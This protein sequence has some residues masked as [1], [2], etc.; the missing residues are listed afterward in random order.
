MK[1]FSRILLVAAIAVGCA[2]AANAQKADLRIGYGGYTQMDGGNYAE[3]KTKTAWGALTA[4]V[5]FKVA[6]KF[7][8]GPSYTFSSAGYKHFDGTA[9]YHVILLNTR[10]EY[11]RNNIVKLSGHLGLGVIITHNSSGDY[12]ETEG[13]FGFHVSPLSAEFALTRGLDFFTEI[14]YGAMGVIQAGVRIS[15]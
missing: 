13:H 6:P 5:D 14:G 1:T 10:Y 8:L 7:R 9:Y 2:T 3:A 12:S 4:E 15:L 11:F